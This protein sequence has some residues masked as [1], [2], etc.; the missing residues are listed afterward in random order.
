MVKRLFLN[1]IVYVAFAFLLLNIT[2]NFFHFRLDLTKEKRFTLHDKTQSTL[3]ANQHKITITVFLDGDMPAAFKRLRNATKDLLNDYK[4]YAKGGLQFE[5]VNPVAGLSAED[6]EHT[7]QQ[8]SQYGIKP[9]QVSIRTDEGVSE[10]LVFPMALVSVDGKQMPVKLLQNMGGEASD[11][12]QSINNSIQNLE[13]AFTSAIRKV[14]SG[15]NPRIGFTEGNGEPDNRHLYDAIS[16]LSES[17][18]VGRVDLNL[19]RNEGLDSLK[20]L[21]ITK[22]L[23]A[24]TEAQKYKINYFVMK[25]GTVVWAIDQV[26]VEL[27]SLRSGASVMSF[28]QS[29]N[30]DDMLFEYGARI[31]YDLLADVNCAEIPVATSG[32]VRG[33]IQLAPW[34]YYPLLM[35]DTTNDVVRNLDFIRSQ[36][37][38]TVDTIGT[39]NVTKKIILRSSPFQKVY[40]SPK[41]FNLGLLEQQ[42]TPQEFNHPPRSMGVLLEGRFKSVFMNRAVPAGID[43]TYDVPEQ[44][45]PSKMFV[46]GDGDVFSNQLASDGSPFALGYDRFTQR[47]YGNKALLINLVDYFT[48]SENLI[49]LRNKEVKVRLLDKTLIKNEKSKWQM[50]NTVLPLLLLISFAIFQ[51]YFRKRKYTR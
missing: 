22:P 47:S 48:S 10:K 37:A 21:I 29:L 8:L 5:F 43:Q 41:L 2:S 38:S 14:I 39:K 15:Y 13:Y 16:T 20:M 17:Y 35:P 36:F 24:F 46:I 30:L 4:S 25:G 51:H 23:K 11:Y 49:A 50:I 45:E 33:D 9:T 26:R 42:P 32:G 44:S 12:D 34:L 40:T 28:N 27:D 1:S 6:K 31:N 18:L 19:I 7:I 3:A